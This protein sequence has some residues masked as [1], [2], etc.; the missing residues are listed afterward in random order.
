MKKQKRLK[1]LD[2]S[3]KATTLADA[4][5]IE[6]LKKENVFHNKDS[7]LG[8]ECKINFKTKLDPKIIGAILYTVLSDSYNK[9]DL[10]TTI[11]TMAKLSEMSED[12]KDKIYTVKV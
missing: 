8:L 9:E 4:T 11:V 12:E 3:I 2:F 5:M 7:L 6:E 1:V 10:I